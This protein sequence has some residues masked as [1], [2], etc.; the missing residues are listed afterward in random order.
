MRKKDMS[1]LKIL[2]GKWVFSA[3]FVALIFSAHLTLS[4]PFFDLQSIELNIFEPSGNLR[5]IPC[6]LANTQ[7][8]LY[9]FLWRG[10]LDYWVLLLPHFF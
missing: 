1:I 9:G 8:C 4:Q 3:V 5:E 10:N 6:G 7:N 2:S